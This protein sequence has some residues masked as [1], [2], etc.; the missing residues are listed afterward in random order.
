MK[1]KMLSIISLWFLLS[2]CSQ[3]GESI[4]LIPKDFT[5][6]VI[7]IFNQ[8]NGMPPEIENG[9][10]VYRIPISGILRTQVKANYKIQGHE[11]YFIDSL[12]NRATIPYKFHKGW[13]DVDTTKIKNNIYCYNEEMGATAENKPDYKKY[14]MFLVG[15]LN[16]IDSLSNIKNRTLFK[17]LA[18]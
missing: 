9:R 13:E 17:A 1:N 2:S 7:I 5:G 8:K 15:K 11:Y 10:H 16:Q 12:G 6:A 18:E 4:C 14:R 3:T